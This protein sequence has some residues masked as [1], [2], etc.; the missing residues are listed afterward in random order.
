MLNNTYFEAKACE[1]MWLIL[2]AAWQLVIEMR[3]TSIEFE[4]ILTF[5]ELCRVEP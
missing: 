1:S 4:A 2:V 5:L 3:L